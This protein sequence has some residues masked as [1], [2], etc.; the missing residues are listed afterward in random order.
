MRDIDDIVAE[1]D[2]RFINGQKHRF[3]TICEE[4]N[5]DGN[6]DINE[7]TDPEDAIRLITWYDDDGYL[8]W[9]QM[10]LG[11]IHRTFKRGSKKIS[12]RD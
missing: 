5:D 12:S 9:R 4:W 2:S 8:W 10:T 1:N 7:E 3:A 6:G 11:E